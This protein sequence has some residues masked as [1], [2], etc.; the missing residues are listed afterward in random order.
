MWHSGRWQHAEYSMSGSFF[1]TCC[2]N[3]PSNK[4]DYGQYMWCMILRNVSRTVEAAILNFSRRYT[5]Q[6]NS[7]RTRGSTCWPSQPQDY[8]TVIRVL[9]DCSGPTGSPSVPPP[10]AAPPFDA[11]N[12]RF[13]SPSSFFRTHATDAVKTSRAVQ[14]PTSP[15][16]S[17]KNA[18][19]AA[20][21]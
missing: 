3:L 4:R 10:L 12:A 1:Y 15:C 11:C 18:S 17:A 7:P 16:V 13:S 6:E 8:R 21:C 20:L 19:Q 2:I 5:R 9:S 14:V